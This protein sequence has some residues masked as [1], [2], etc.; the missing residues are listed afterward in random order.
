MV[1]LYFP[2][3]ERKLYMNLN[4]HLELV[5][6]HAPISPSKYNLWMMDDDAEFEKR[7]AMSYA[8]ELGTQLHNEARKRIEH[9]RRLN[10]QDKRSIIV[11]ILD[12]GIPEKV[13]GYFPFNDMYDNLCTYVN[14]A[15]S[16]NMVPECGIWYC[17]MCFGTADALVYDEQKQ[18][19]R[20][21]DLK[22]GVTVAK[23]EQLHAYAALFFLENRFIRP[24]EVKTELRIYQNNDIL[25]DEPSADFIVEIMEKLK[26]RLDI[27]NKMKG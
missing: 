11:N 18:F 16:F 4:R 2:K 25:T 8:Q 9:K 10:N 6:K 21:H 27:A 1:V 19:L 5:G 7:F 26:H 23:M 13:L 15:I 3:T 20:I 12:A 17:E 22:T 24:G 14:D